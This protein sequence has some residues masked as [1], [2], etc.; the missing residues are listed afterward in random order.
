HRYC[1]KLYLLKAQSHDATQEFFWDGRQPLR[2]PAL[3]QNLIFQMVKN[4]GLNP[5]I[6]GKNLCVRF[7][8]GGEK[9]KPVGQKHTRTLKNLLQQQSIP[10]WQRE[11]IPLLYLNDELIAVCGY[12]LADAYAVKTGDGLLPVLVDE[13]SNLIAVP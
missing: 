11:R 4:G 7:R 9:I 3:Q 2:I 12:W 8:Q 1:K 5:E 13:H 10:P 6:A